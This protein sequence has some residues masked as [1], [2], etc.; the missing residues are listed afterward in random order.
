[1]RTPDPG[2]LTAA[3]ASFNPSI[4]PLADG[5]LMV[6][7]LETAQIGHAAFTAGVELHELA[8]EKADLEAVFLQLTAGKAGIR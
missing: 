4:T 5:T 3:L 6:A 8:G 1:V 7:G 2:K